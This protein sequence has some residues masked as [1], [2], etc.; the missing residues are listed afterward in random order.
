MVL[1]I[2]QLGKGSQLLSSHSNVIVGSNR[3]SGK[4]IAEGISELGCEKIQG[5]YSGGKGSQH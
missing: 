4:L 3:S 1:Y 2:Q 5:M